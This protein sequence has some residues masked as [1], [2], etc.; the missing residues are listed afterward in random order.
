[1]KKPTPPAILGRTLLWLKI[2]DFVGMIRV[3]LVV[4]FIIIIII[5]LIKSAT[6]M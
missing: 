3:R 6:L 4:V 5:Y 1:L 2:F